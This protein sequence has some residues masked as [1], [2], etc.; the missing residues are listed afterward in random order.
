M[1]R[2]VAWISTVAVL[3]LAESK[4]KEP[5]Q[6]EWGLATRHD[7]ASAEWPQCLPLVDTI[8]KWREKVP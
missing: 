5:T 8:V 6:S 4:P 1:T 2:T 3:W 7:M